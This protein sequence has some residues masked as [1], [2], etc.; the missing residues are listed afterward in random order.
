MC[1]LT[2]TLKNLISLLFQKQIQNL[3]LPGWTSFF[4]D[5]LFALFGI[6]LA[7]LRMDLGRNYQYHFHFLNCFL[8]LPQQLVFFEQHL[9]TEGHEGL[10]L[11]SFGS[12]EK[13]NKKI[14]YKGIFRKIRSF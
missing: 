6:I 1:F 10:F 8:P 14:D 7:E 11:S 5:M 2:P 12:L 4:F 13:V 9:H 3:T